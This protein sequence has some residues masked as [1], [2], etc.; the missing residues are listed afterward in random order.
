[1][2]K[3]DR[4]TIE[5]ALA[6]A[7]ANQTEAAYRRTDRLDARRPLMQEWAEYLAR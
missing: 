6:H 3:A 1:M 2:H 7:N 4:E 5:R